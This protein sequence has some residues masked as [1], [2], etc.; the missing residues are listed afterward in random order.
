M[1]AKCHQMG[2]PFLIQVPPVGCKGGLVV[3]WKSYIDA[4]PVI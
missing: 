1:Q 4:E 3:A 2:F